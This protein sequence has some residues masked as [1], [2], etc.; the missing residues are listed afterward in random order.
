M[1]IFAIVLSWYEPTSMLIVNAMFH[2]YK[3]QWIYFLHRLLSTN[4]LIF[5]LS[6]SMYCMPCFYWFICLWISIIIWDMYWIVS[7]TPRSGLI[8]CDWIF[9]FCNSNSI[10]IEWFP[11]SWKIRIFSLPSI[12]PLTKLSLKGIVVSAIAI[13]VT[14]K[15]VIKHALTMAKILMI[16]SLVLK[17]I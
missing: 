10:K 14:Y 3:L 15:E 7:I 12:V 2:Y 1:I 6:I 8:R 4:H 5:L 9:A 13:D 11:S 17:L 16:W